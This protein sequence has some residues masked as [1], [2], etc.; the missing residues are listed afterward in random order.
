MPRRAKGPR[1]YLRTSVTDGRTG[2][3]LPAVW[4]IRDGARER[5]T[6]CGPQ[7]QEAA[8]RALG[9][10]LAEK[11]TAP[12]LAAD[13]RRDPAQVLVAEVVALYSQDKA[14]ASGLDK[15]TFDRFVANLLS[16]WGERFLSDVKRST[17][18][19]YAAHR[20]GQADARYKDPAAAPRVSSETARR[21]LEFLSASVGYWHGE[22]TLTTRP[23]VWLPDKPES[24]RDALTRSQA[25]A[26]LKAALGSRKDLTGR[27]QRLGASARA[28]RA[29]LRRF[30]LIGF[31]TGTRPGVIPKLLWEESATQAWIDVDRGVIWR[32]GK[33]EREHKTKR[34]PLVK[35]PPRLLTHLR[36]W[37]AA[38]ARLMTAR[39]AKGLPITNTVL[40]HGGRPI[41]GKIRTGY[42]GCVA[43]A[44]LPPEVTP[45]WQRHSAATWLME[46]GAILWDAAGYLGMTV[47]TLEKHYG[48][49]RPDY[50]A[51]AA[52]ASGGKR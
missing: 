2:R 33:L 49:H 46:G 43:D 26:L 45:H 11:F 3:P 40:H 15:A 7:Q 41:T 10:Y 25:A 29:H 28:N 4:V 48:H 18:K 21:E 32:K 31:Y 12:A 34:R 36:R 51:G 50:Q 30:M 23:V 5:S 39:D 16:W 37:K 38:D 14:T 19:A 6:G 13:S 8:E 20:M 1:L 24:P 35:V 42:E 27:W 9:D 52:R 47:D 17:C 44:G 22:D